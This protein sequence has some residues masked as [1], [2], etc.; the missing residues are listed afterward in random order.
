M[1]AAGK[2]RVSQTG[3]GAAADTSDSAQRWGVFINGDVDIGRQSTVGEQSGF[4]ITSKGITIGADYRLAGNDVLGASVGFVKAD[5]DLDAGGGNQNANGY[6]FSFYGSYVPTE[7]AYIDGILNVGHNRYSSQRQTATTSLDSN[8]TGNQWGVAV[9]AGYAFNRG[10]L[11]LTPYGRVEYVDAKVN[12][13]TENGDV[14]Q[15]LM[16]GEQQIK[17]TTLSLGGSASYAIST[18]WGVLLPYGRLEFQYLAQSNANDV[19][20]QIASAASTTPA[21]IQVVGGDK[22]FGNF[23]AG[24]S[25]LFGHGVS[26]F[27]NYQQLFGKRDVRDQL[28]TLGFRAEF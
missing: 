6:S 26:A 3:G 7:N 20:V 9:S 5:T 27:F 24:L 11:A 4:K 10:A 21:L 12:G 1:S 17:A 2:D 16:I 14:A 22:S 15:A 8:T 19:T 13:F 23:A 18:S 28:Y 25:A